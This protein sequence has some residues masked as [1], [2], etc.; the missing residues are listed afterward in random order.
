MNCG[1]LLASLFVRLSLQHN[2]AFNGAVSGAGQKTQ[3]Y[4][5][6]VRRL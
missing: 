3:H 1:G 2:A 5:R 4:G 6:L